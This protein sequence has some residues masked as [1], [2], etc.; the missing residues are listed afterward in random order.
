MTRGKWSAPMNP[1]PLIAYRA[2]APPPPWLVKRAEQRDPFLPLDISPAEFLAQTSEDA[3]A[4]AI[5][6]QKES[7]APKKANWK[8]LAFGAGGLAV[9]LGAIALLRRRRA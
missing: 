1:D 4:T 6:A 3:E 8:W 5:S 9:A 7:A 2:D